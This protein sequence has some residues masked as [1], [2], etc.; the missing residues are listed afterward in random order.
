[1]RFEIRGAGIAAI[2]V[3]VTLLSCVVFVLGLLA[4]YDVGREAQIAT[5]QVTT[6]Y[7]LQPPP[8]AAASVSASGNASPA[9]EAGGALDAA[10]SAPNPAPAQMRPASNVAPRRPARQRIAAS[11][12]APAGPAKAPPPPPPVE[13]ESAPPSET[14]PPEAAPLSAET[15]AERTAAL[16]NPA[17]ARI[18]RK[19]YNIQ[20]QAAMDMD[21]ANQMIRRLQQL[22]YSPHLVPTD[23][24]GQRWYKVE[25]GPY[26]TQDEAASAESQLRQKYNATYG[27][28]GQPARAADSDSE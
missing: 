19:P 1:M 22:G 26:A 6:A 24:G 27:G 15:P 4:G 25:V 8:A 5:T 23:I 11:N 16:E 18:H 21:G 2:L 28:G 20:I 9:P 12:V 3:T 13:A 7:P 10:S 14:E 17:P